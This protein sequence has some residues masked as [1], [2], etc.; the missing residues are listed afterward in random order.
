[1]QLRFKSLHSDLKAPGLTR[2][3]VEPPMFWKLACTI[4]HPCCQF[5]WAQPAWWEKATQMGLVAWP[6]VIQ[7]QA[8]LMKYRYK[9]VQFPPS[10]LQCS[11]D[12]TATQT[13]GHSS[14]VR[15]SMRP[16]TPVLHDS[17]SPNFAEG[18]EWNLSQIFNMWL[19]NAEKVFEVKD[20]SR[21]HTECSNGTGMHFHGVVLRLTY[22]FFNSCALCF[23][24]LIRNDS[25]WCVISGVKCVS[26]KYLLWS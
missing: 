24:G 6:I 12:H 21:D 7:T 2:S 5:I 1:M 26:T 8:E 23:L 25:C 3:S 16:L 4:D 11:A 10:F 20:Q 22:L 14:T 19:G 18:F 13:I 15:L 9:A 17:I